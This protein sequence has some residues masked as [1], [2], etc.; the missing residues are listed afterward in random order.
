[1]HCSCAWIRRNVPEQTV[2]LLVSWDSAQ[3]FGAGRCIAR[4]LGF[5]AMLRCRPVQCHQP[6]WSSCANVA[7]ASRCSATDCA[8]I[9]RNGRGD[10]HSKNAAGASLRPATVAITWLR[11]TCYDPKGRAQSHLPPEDKRKIK[12]SGGH[13]YVA[14]PTP[15]G[16]RATPL[17]LGANTICNTV[18]S[19]TIVI[20]FLVFSS[21]YYNAFYPFLC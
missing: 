8:T 9:R 5:G 7:S 21:K 3:C 1:M 15:K 10:P 18:L 12:K 16:V 2:A 17:S 11:W 13:A 14:R 4:V 20:R 19:K 6:A